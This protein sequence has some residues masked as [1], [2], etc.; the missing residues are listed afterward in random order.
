ML[1]SYKNPTL[2]PKKDRI[3][4][5]IGIAQAIQIPNVAAIAPKAPRII[6][7]NATIAPQRSPLFSNLTGFLSFILVN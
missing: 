1:L 2:I 6:R 5:I 4:A 7:K 3:I